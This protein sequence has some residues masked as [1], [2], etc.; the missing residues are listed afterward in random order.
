MTVK[1]VC[2][3]FGITAD[4]LRYYE[5]V[6]AIPKVART[7]G[8]IREYDAE[9][10]GWVRNAVCLRKAGVSVEAIAEYVR[11][12]EMGD[13]TLKDRLELL[14]GERNGLK[15]QLDELTAAVE[16]LD[17]KIS[18]YREAVKTGVLSWEKNE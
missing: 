7:K 9:A 15:T 14:I 13:G 12:F 10:I 17:W 16:L 11:L 6:G 2:E 1:D 5:R 4:T 18:R 8:G 3:E